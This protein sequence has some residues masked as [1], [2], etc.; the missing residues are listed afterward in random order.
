[1]VVKMYKGISYEGVVIK[2][3]A[4]N[5]NLAI[6]AHSLTVSMI[7]LTFTNLWETISDI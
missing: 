3:G 7:S 2:F 6:I 4:S 5:P 1:M